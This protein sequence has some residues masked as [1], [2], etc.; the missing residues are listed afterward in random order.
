M[1]GKLS[2][3][4]ILGVKSDSKQEEIKR[5]YFKAVRKYPP[6]RFPDEFRKIREAYEILSDEESRE[7]YDLSLEGGQ[8]G[9][10]FIMAYEAMDEE[11]YDEAVKLLKEVL[12]IA[13]ANKMAKNLIGICLLNKEEHQEAIKYYKKLI[14]QSSEDEY[15]YFNLGQAYI[16]AKALKKALENFKKA[17]KLEQNVSDFWV[18]TGYC[19]FAQGDHEKARNI[20][21]EGMKK[22]GEDLSFLIKLIQIDITQRDRKKLLSN[23]KRIEKLA[24]DHKM[25]ENVSWTFYEIAEE[26]SNFMPDFAETLLK[27]AKKLNP[28]DEKINAYHKK[29]SKNQKL[30]GSIEKLIKDETVHPWIK[31]IVIMKIMGYENLLEE[32]DLDISR[33]LFLRSPAQA[34]SSAKHIKSE[35]PDLFKHNKDFL[36]NII[37][38]P[39]GI[40]ID[41]KQ[42]LEDIKEIERMKGEFSEFQISQITLDEIFIMPMPKRNTVMVGRNDPCPCGSG[43]KYKKCCL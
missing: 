27:K 13:P 37:D 41:E 12:E 36:Q 39:N 19:Y 24:T 8:G 30:Q 42:L 23:I 5:G 29:V 16:K 32:K 2:L 4:D 14:S 40:I 7:D 18:Q 26:L 15:Y 20:L 17:L 22:C 21:E 34:F 11:R 10:K 1:Q 9:S 33:R 35:Y 31:D 43:K 28:K 3:Y 6:E 38:Y 25:K